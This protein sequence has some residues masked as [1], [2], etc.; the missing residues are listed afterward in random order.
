MSELNRLLSQLLIAAL[1]FPAAP[2][3]RA[4]VYDAHPKLVIL[5]VIDQFRGDYLD[6]YRAG[7]KG[8]GFR[9][10]LD[11]G[12]YFEDCYY[13]YA[14]TKTAPGHATLG[15]GSY[16]DGHGISAN[17]WWDLDRNKQR[18]V[19]SVEDGRYKLV[20]PPQPGNPSPS[21]SP[22]NSSPISASPDASP[23]NHSPSASP[24]NP[25]PG[26]SPLNLRASTVG[27]QL[28]LA[29]QGQSAVFGISL[30]DRAAILPAGYSA[31][32]AYWID[33]TSGYFITSSFYM[34]SLPNWVNAFNIGGR[35]DEAKKEANSPTDGAFYETVGPTPAANSYELDFARA[36]I[37]NENLGRHA[38]TDMLTLSLSANDLLGHRYGPDSADEEEMVDTLDQQLDSFF[39]WLDKNIPGGL[40]NVWIAFSADHGVA[41]IPAQAE[42]LG[43]PA[44]TIDLRK[45]VASLNDT[46]NAKFSPGE[47]VEYLL[48]QQELPYL[49]L[50]RPSFEVA[51]INEQEA[52]QAIQ[53]AVPAAVA[54]LAPTEG[55]TL[56]PAQPISS[57]V[58]TPVPSGKPA[59]RTRA[60]RRPGSKQASAKNAA[61]NTEPPPIPA[62]PVVRMVPPP[63]VVHT[64]TRQQL[65]AG[66]LP[67]SEWGQL[68]AHSYSPNGGWYVMVIPAAYQMEVLPRGTTHFSPWSYDRHVPLGFFGAPFTPGIYHGRV[69][70][71]DLAATLASLLGVNQPSASIGAVLNQAIHTPPPQPAPR[72]HARAAAAE[73]TAT[74][75][76]PTTPESGVIPYYPKEQTPQ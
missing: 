8:R 62:P 70:P 66:D 11:H 42:S 24:N 65:A 38:V 73:T 12:A 49:S 18:P 20:G 40:A 52:E 27:D 7:F 6:R 46:M 19:T 23:G 56:P 51:G 25:N 29:T 59:R 5:L 45:L 68:L 48:P 1:L 55:E 30:K 31:N 43:V 28:R 63:L 2:V 71:V 10:F 34:P 4:S 74:P 61:P 67:P 47:K 64:Y 21:A 44:A 17:E 9:L 69:Q 72:G 13:D 35:I 53:Q 15:T 33:P 37:Q 58:V 75:A 32:A 16:T 26:A 60:S 39:T 41:P 50:N 22:S 76:T 36:L 3:A 57:P 54:A 14:N